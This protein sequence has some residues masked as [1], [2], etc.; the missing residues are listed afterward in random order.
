ML[1]S[2]Y[3]SIP[4]GPSYASLVV[5]TTEGEGDISAGR[6]GELGASFCVGAAVRAA[7]SGA[8]VSGPGAPEV[9]RVRELPDE[10]GIDLD[11]LPPVLQPHLR[12]PACGEGP[13]VHRLSSSSQREH[14]DEW[15][16]EQSSQCPCLMFWKS[17]S[18]SDGFCFYSCSFGSCSC[19]LLQYRS[20]L[21]IE[22]VP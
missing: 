4:D 17:S 8:A 20:M 21:M 5:E 6:N 12:L 11:P 18:G 16:T 14:R 2:L 19:F 22:L 15:L 9:C 13:P 10:R 1:P 3:I 7:D